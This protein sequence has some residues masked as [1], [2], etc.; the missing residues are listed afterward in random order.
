MWRPSRS[1]GMWYQI[2]IEGDGAVK[3]PHGRPV[4]QAGSAFEG[5]RAGRRNPTVVQ[6][7]SCRIRIRGKKGGRRTLRSSSM[8]GWV[9][10]GGEKGG[11][12][13]PRSSS[14]PGW[15]RTRGRKGREK[16]PTVVQYARLDPHSGKRRVGGGPNG[17]PVCRVGSV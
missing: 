15:I 4:C 12:R 5:R 9:R 17:R 14:V 1:S 13:D 7:V 6:F 2:R 10:I 3:K 16:D 11:R 8:P